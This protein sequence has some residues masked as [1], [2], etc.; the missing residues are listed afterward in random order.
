MANVVQAT[1]QIY[2]LAATNP[3][4]TSTTASK[5]M[6]GLAGSFTP[7]NS[8]RVMLTMVGDVRNATAGN[9]AQWQMRYGTGTTPVNGDADTGTAAGGQQVFVAGSNTN[10]V[11]LSCTTFITTLT[12]GVT[13]WFD[14]ALQAVTAGTATINNM[15]ILIVEV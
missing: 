2:E 12:G 1:K 3:A 8:S 4:G 7:R 9:G 11:P 13:Y 5:V 15:R 14:M 6:M 10:R